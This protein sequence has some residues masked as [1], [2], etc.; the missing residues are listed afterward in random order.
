MGTFSE[1]LF[2]FWKT[3]E[4]PAGRRQRESR[5]GGRVQKNFC[6]H[7]ISPS[8]TFR[9]IMQEE[10]VDP[11]VE[12]PKNPGFIFDKR[13]FDVWVSRAFHIIASRKLGRIPTY[14]ETKALAKKCLTRTITSKSGTHFFTITN[15]KNKI[16]QYPWTLPNGETELFVS[17]VDLNIFLC[18]HEE[19]SQRARDIE[20]RTDME[21]KRSAA[22]LGEEDCPALKGVGST[23][24]KSS[25]GTQK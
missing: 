8:I 3:K 19:F 5:P 20:L 4:K 10:K 13:M 21:K 12:E 18:T 9:K 22:L 2:I 24:E 25:E 6:E 11:S 17:Q 23:P 1:R 7:T 14:E 15:R 16:F